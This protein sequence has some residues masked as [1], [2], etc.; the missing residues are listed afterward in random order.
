ME[1]IKWINGIYKE[2]N[3]IFDSDWEAYEWADG[4]HSDIVPDLAAK[5]NVGYA[6]P[7]KKVYSNLLDLIPEWVKGMD[8]KVNIHTN[9]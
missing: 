1:N 8:V 3:R 9:E 6:T 2:D 4:L 5:V 7:D